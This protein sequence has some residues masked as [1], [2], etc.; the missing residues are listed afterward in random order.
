MDLGQ[1]VTMT[2]K[3]SGFPLPLR[4][5]ELLHN[6]VATSI[7]PINN[8]PLKSTTSSASSFTIVSVNVSHVGEYRCRQNTSNTSLYSDATIKL[9]GMRLM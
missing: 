7:Q 1:T 6:E 4:D 2:C 5:M 3:V 9:E 8:F